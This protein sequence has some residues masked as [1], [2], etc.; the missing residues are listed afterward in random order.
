MFTGISIY[1]QFV[2][3]FII[4]EMLINMKEI[5]I[6]IKNM[7]LELTLFSNPLLDI[8]LYPVIMLEI[9][10]ME[11][12]AALVNLFMKIINIKATG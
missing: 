9:G 8:Q 11:F 6:K 3:L 10:Q 12:Q 1:K 5:F 2:Y 7:D 4:S